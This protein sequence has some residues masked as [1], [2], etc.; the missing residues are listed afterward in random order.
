MCL[1]NPVKE[2]IKKSRCLLKLIRF[3]K[4]KKA[5]E[6]Q[7]I[8]KVKA[9]ITC[10]SKMFLPQALSPKFKTRTNV[11]KSIWMDYKGPVTH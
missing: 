5:A 8:E 9:N 1:R 2:I 11:L 7:K 4:M 3:N 6:N 10:Y